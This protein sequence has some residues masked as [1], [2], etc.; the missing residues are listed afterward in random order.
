ME[1]PFER[2]NRIESKMR[3]DIVLD[4]I[5]AE[6]RTERKREIEKKNEKRKQIKN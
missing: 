2:A 3:F 5:W 4:S 1:I 6:F